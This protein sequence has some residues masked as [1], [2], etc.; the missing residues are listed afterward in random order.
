MADAMQ[1]R[2]KTKL[3]PMK[4]LLCEKS[5][6]R[7]V[8]RNLWNAGVKR[9]LRSLE[10]RRLKR[11]VI[12]KIS[13]ERDDREKHEHGVDGVTIAER[14]VRYVIDDWKEQ[15]KNGGWKSERV[16]GTRQ[17]KYS[18]QGAD[19]KKEIAGDDGANESGI[20]A[21]EIGDGMFG[22]EPGGDNSSTG[23][24]HKKRRLATNEGSGDAPFFSEI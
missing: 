19:R 24:P 21:A 18:Q 17:K 5:P 14:G 7:I 11:A 22:A 10:L 4:I 1:R 9:F 3:R 12:R 23:E 2:K 15:G 20:S 16:S 8:Q 6:L 13:G